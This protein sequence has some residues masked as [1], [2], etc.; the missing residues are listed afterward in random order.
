MYYP[1]PDFNYSYTKPIIRSV[2]FSLPLTRSHQADSHLALSSDKSKP[3][4]EHRNASWKC[5]QNDVLPSDHDAFARG[6]SRRYTRSTTRS[7]RAG[8]R[9]GR[10]RRSCSGVQGNDTA[11]YSSGDS[12]IG[13]LLG[14]C[15]ICSKV[16][17]RGAVSSLA[18]SLESWEQIETHGGLMTPAMP[19]WQCI[20]S[21]Q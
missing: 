15:Y 10:S 4:E 7:F 5:I 16:V 8:C 13:G 20:V 21:E 9:R 6:L 12:T 3:K 19:N 11:S 1:L 14:S 18:S 17:T 2:S